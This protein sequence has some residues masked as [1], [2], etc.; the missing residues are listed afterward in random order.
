MSQTG[1]SKSTAPYPGEHWQSV[2]DAP[3][4]QNLRLLEPPC[5]HRFTQL[6]RV[7]ETLLVCSIYRSTHESVC[8]A[9]RVNEKPNYPPKVVDAVDD[10]GTQSVR[11]I[12]LIEDLIIGNGVI[13]EPV[14]KALCVQVNADRLAL[15]V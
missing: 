6:A 9:V 2:H 15:I 14:A 13:H 8:I 5:A 1:L 12:D 11:I 3:E 7:I 4:T 10:G